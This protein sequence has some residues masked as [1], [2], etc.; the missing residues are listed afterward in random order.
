M[1]EQSPPTTVVVG[2]T[3]GVGLAIARR[4][5]AHDL[6]LLARESEKFG[7]LQGE[8]LDARCSAVDFQDL[9]SLEMAV[10]GLDRIDYL[11]QATGTIAPS[12]VETST[13]ADW[14][15]MM[16]ANVLAPMLATRAALPGLRAARGTIV[17]ISSGS[18]RRVK[19][20]WSGY[21]ASKSACD[22]LAR[23]VQLEE[24]DIAVLSIYAGSIDTP[25]REKL[26]ETVGVD[27][28]SHQYLSADDIA[29]C[30]SFAI[31]RSDSA[32]IYEI[33]L[34]PRR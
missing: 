16:D 28:E 5:R 14:S 17:F 18:A 33:A 24:P 21:A 3:G 32:D 20:G 2:A 19:P 1:A 30:T 23:A 31:E 15:D 6:V 10:S 29:A 7:E 8:F 4:L 22:A 9:S 11:V 26:G 13:R 25:M 27:Y 12:R 34:R